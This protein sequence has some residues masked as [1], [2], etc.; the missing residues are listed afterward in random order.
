MYCNCSPRVRH[1][2]SVKYTDTASLMISD[3]LWTKFCHDNGTRSVT[4][5]FLGFYLNHIIVGNLENLL[6]FFFLKSQYPHS[7]FLF[8]ILILPIWL[9]MESTHV[10]IWNA[11]LFNPTWLS[12]SDKYVW[13]DLKMIMSRRATTL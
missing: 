4:N 11:S 12:N 6:C 10:R 1:S 7:L 9:I 2:N 8:L 13:S 5:N 3:Q